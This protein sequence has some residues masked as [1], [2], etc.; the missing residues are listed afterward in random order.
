MNSFVHKTTNEKVEGHTVIGKWADGST[1]TVEEDFRVNIKSEY[2]KIDA[3]EVGNAIV[4][5]LACKM[6]I[7]QAQSGVRPNP[8]DCMNAAKEMYNLKNKT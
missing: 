2:A 8:V 6:L 5:D 4:F 1:K 3:N 7:A